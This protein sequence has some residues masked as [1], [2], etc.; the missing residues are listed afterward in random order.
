MVKPA[1]RKKWL[2]FVSGVLWLL[3]GLFFCLRAF[4]WLKPLALKGL[5]LFSLAL[6]LS[7]LVG[8]LG[9]S[10]IAFRNLRRLD[11]QPDKICCF[12]FQPWRSYLIIGLMILLGVTLRRSSLPRPL[13]GFLYAVMGGGLVTASFFYFRG[14][15]VRLKRPR[16]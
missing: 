3:V 16:P 11:E 10:R 1:V 7:F 14:G 2:Y 4:F 15:W 8:R 5:G 6:V 13:L 9:L 12:A